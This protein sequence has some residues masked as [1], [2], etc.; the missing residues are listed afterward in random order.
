MQKLDSVEIRDS[1]SSTIRRTFL[2]LAKTLVF[3][4]TLWGYCL[5]IWEAEYL[6]LGGGNRQPSRTYTPTVSGDCA[7]TALPP[8]EIVDENA[9]ENFTGLS[10]ENSLR[11]FRACE[12]AVGMV[13]EKTVGSIFRD[14]CVPCVPCE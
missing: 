13:V 6:Q 5:A 12:R 4:S 11:V 1:C 9:K 14:L 7:D 3:F 10:V 8:L 2:K